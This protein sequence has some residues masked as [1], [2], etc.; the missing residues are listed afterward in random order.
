[1]ES[2]IASDRRSHVAH[3]HVGEFAFDKRENGM[4]IEE[5][6]GLGHTSNLRLSSSE[7]KVLKKTRLCIV[8]LT[9]VEILEQ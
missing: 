2:V 4:S 6:T 7:I 9:S 1:M 3:Q 8:S 5:L